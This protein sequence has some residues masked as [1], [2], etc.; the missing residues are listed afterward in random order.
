MLLTLFTALG[1]KMHLQCASYYCAQVDN[2]QQPAAP[3]YLCFLLNG[4]A[5]N[6]NNTITTRHFY[7]SALSHCTRWN[8]RIA[9]CAPS[10]KNSISALA[11]IYA[12]IQCAIIALNLYRNSLHSNEIA[13]WKMRCWCSASLLGECLLRCFQWRCALPVCQIS[14]SPACAPCDNKVCRCLTCA[15]LIYQ[16]V[17]LLSRMGG[18]VICSL[19]RMFASLAAAHYIMPSY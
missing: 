16:F 15:L 6:A 8:D 11:R 9:L 14:A 10:F 19:P 1:K 2:K 17:Q 18:N 12:F 13:A 4:Y 5:N 7:Y 3:F